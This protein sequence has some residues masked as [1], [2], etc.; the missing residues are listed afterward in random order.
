VNQLLGACCQVLIGTIL[1]AYSGRSFYLLLDASCSHDIRL[2]PLRIWYDT[3]TTGFYV[4]NADRT[5]L[6]ENN[7][8]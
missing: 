7:R 5:K 1:D 2:R 3:P 6:E 8:K 4:K